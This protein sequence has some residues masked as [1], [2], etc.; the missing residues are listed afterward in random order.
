MD[1]CDRK[2][3]RVRMFV[4]HGRN[5]VNEFGTKNESMESHEISF[6][7]GHDASDISI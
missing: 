7:C 1:L 3:L 5:R 2:E 6:N 4:R